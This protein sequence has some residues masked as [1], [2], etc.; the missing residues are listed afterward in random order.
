M[1]HPAHVPISLL[2]V[3]VTQGSV[4]DCCVC[5]CVVVLGKKDLSFSPLEGGNFGKV[6][7]Y[8]NLFQLLYG[9]M[10]MAR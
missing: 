4:C 9:V 8:F 7:G 1:Y 6:K 5:I 3:T 10:T 2:V